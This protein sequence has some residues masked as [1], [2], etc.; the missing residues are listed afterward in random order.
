MA[1]E[2]PFEDRLAIRELIDSYGD[3]VARNDAEAWGANWA[4]DSVWILNL[5]DLPR[6][7][8]RSNIVALWVRAMSEYEWVLM[9]SKP[10]EIRI[11]GDR[12]TGCFYTAEVTRLKSGEEQR[13]SGRYE[14]EYVRRNGRWLIGRRTYTMLHLQSLG[15]SSGMG[16]WKGSGG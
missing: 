16:S 6:V 3:A 15:K 1:F 8:G 2:G 11:S 10:G 14:D 12:A 4:E 7:E 9:T 5:P 13:I